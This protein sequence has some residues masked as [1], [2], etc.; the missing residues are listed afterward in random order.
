LR[1]TCCV[2]FF[3]SFG[4]GAAGGPTGLAPPVQVQTNKS[5]QEGPECINEI[6]HGWE[7]YQKRATRLQGS[8]VFRT[9]ILPT[10]EVESEYR[11][12]LKQR[13]ES[14]LFEVQR[15]SKLYKSGGFSDAVVSNASYG[16]KLHQQLKNPQWSLSELARQPL[17]WPAI[18]D[19]D[20]LATVRKLIEVPA[21]RNGIWSML[22]S[23]LIT[24]PGFKI[25]EIMESDGLPGTRVRFSHVPGPKERVPSARGYFRLK[26]DQMWIVLGYEVELSSGF[27]NPPA[28]VFQRLTVEY[29][30]L[31]D[32]FPIPKRVIVYHKGELKGEPREVE[33]ILEYDLREED[34]PDSAFLL[35]AYG[36]P[37]P[38]NVATPRSGQNFW[39]LGAIVGGLACLVLAVILRR[40]IGNP[41]SEGLDNKRTAAP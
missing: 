19:Q 22:M 2:A 26:K 30:S 14:A 9:E 12:V 15:V 39:F 13:G 37:E 23:P 25:E 29:Q 20:A 38:K 28:T 10:R 36:M 32:G 16:F 4:A 33:G 6:W 34:I 18:S 3:A 41:A 7:A 1:V 27:Q 17:N 31:A 8:V 21:P 24:H 5:N 35:S 11:Y 40:R